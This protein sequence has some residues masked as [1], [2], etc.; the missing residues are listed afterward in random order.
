MRRIGTNLSLSFLCVLLMA[1][2]ATNVL[3]FS[4]HQAHVIQAA[5]KRVDL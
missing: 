2:L 1:A 5:G 4:P 3:Q